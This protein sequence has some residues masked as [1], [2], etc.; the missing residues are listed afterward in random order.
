MSNQTAGL[1]FQL[2][3]AAALLGCAWSFYR[4]HLSSRWLA[5]AGEVLE[6]SIAQDADLNSIPN[7]RYR[8]TV[9]G[10]TYPHGQLATTGSYAAKLVSRYPSGQ[11]VRVYYNPDQPQDATLRRQLPLWVPSLQ[12]V[13]GVR[14]IAMG[15][16]FVGQV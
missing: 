16:F 14:F 3:G 12:L 11:I 9:R 4:Q 8:Y 7:I 15:L 13:A 10:R 5:T 2:L 1:I 6:S